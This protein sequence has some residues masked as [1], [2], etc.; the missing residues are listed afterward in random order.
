[1]LP[2]Q[3]YLYPCQRSQSNWTSTSHAFLFCTIAQTLRDIQ[4]RFTQFKDKSTSEPHIWSCETTSGRV[5]R[6]MAAG[7]AQTTFH[8][9]HQQKH[10]WSGSHLILCQQSVHSVS[11]WLDY[12]VLYFYTLLLLYYL[13]LWLSKPNKTTNLTIT[14]TQFAVNHLIIIAAS[15]TEQ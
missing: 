3:P 14:W 12:F 9:C 13:M 11:L 5:R 1:V 10:N 15:E 2:D 8:Q 7:N 4:R 6:R